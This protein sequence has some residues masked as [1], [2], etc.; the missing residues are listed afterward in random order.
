MLKLEKIAPLS[1]MALLKRPLAMGE[2]ICALT[3]CDPA[4]SPKMV[5]FVGSPPKA[6][7]L[8]RT[9]AMAAVWS[10]RP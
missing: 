9:Q 3:D 1:P 10:I 4:D 2:A 5:M 6:A 7:M 8:R